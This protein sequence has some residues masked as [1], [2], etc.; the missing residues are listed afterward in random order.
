MERLGQRFSKT[1]DEIAGLIE[2]ARTAYQS[3]S[4][5]GGA[6]INVFYRPG[7]PVFT[8]YRF[9]GTAILTFYSHKGRGGVPTLVCRAGGTLYS[10]VRDELDAIRDQSRAAP[11]T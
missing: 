11:T 5:P 7:D 3:M 9:D 2:A 8:C 4:Q 1:A 10:F 6:E